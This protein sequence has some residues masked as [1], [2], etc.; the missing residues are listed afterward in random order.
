VAASS[1]GP[2]VRYE[3]RGAVAL[4]TIDHPPVN[5]LS[6]AVLDALRAALERAAADPGARVVVLAGA[7]ERAF[8]AGADIK[9]MAPMG[10]AEAHVHGGRGQGVTTAIEALRLPVIAA[11]HGSCLGG[12]CEI[13][14]A[15]DFILASDDAKF[16]QPEINLGV[17]PGWGGTRRL[18][19][20]IG[21]ARARAWI[22][23]GRPASAQEAFDQGLLHEVVPREDLLAR[24][25]ALADELA[26]KPSTAL[27]AAKFAL[28]RSIDPSIQE[29]LAYELQLWSELFDTP[30][31]KEGMA[32]FLEKRAARFESRPEWA[33]LARRFPQ[34]PAPSTHSTGEAAREKRMN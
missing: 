33:S 4:L 13:A 14:L 12:G 2:L 10:P 29:G 30:D 22:L 18:P 8:A 9:E 28:Q 6:A 27:A 15:C 3:L 1:A 11:V 32:A 20:R 26:T 24:A 5:V 16:G 7:A 17:M 34:H 23:L 19:R 25:L 31:Q 21:A